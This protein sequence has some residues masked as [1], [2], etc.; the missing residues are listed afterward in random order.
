MRVRKSAVIEVP[1][2]MFELSSKPKKYAYS[3]EYK[4]AF[5]AQLLGYAESKGQNLGSAYHRYKEKFG[6]YPSM[7]KPEPQAPS[8]EVIQFVRS[9]NIAYAKKR[10]A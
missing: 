6:V 1:G 3:M 9:R 7:A 10:S 8:L 2:E 4:S 5:Y